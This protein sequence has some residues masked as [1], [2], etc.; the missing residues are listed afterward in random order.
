MLRDHARA[1][2][3]DYPK[4][5]RQS[6][7]YRLDRLDPF[8]LSKLIVGSEGTLAIVTGA[9]LRLV[10]LPKAKMFAVGHFDSLLGAIDATHDA[11]ELAPS[12]VEMI[13]RTIL[14]LSRA[15]LEFRAPRR[16]LEGDPEAL[17]FVSF[18]GDTEAEVRDKLDQLE[19]AWGDNGHGYHFLRAETAAEQDA[20]TKVRK[21]GLGLL[22]AASE[23]RT[24]PAA[25]VED[26][27]VRARAPARVRR[28]L[29][30][31]LRRARAERRLLRPLLGGLPAHPPVPRPLAARPGRD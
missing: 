18:S 14:G 10:E 13:D 22:M 9:T 6:G 2:A 4:H 7:G 12:A 17:L 5:W 30:G 25:F 24:R 23:G 26:T 1:I 29:P 15:K 20:L 16:P 28:A 19:R 31:D 3:E 8:D 21:A 27:A 11:L